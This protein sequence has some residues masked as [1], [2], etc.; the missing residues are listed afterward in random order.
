MDADFCDFSIIQFDMFSSPDIGLVILL[1][2][3]KSLLRMFSF[4]DN[5]IIFLFKKRKIHYKKILTKMM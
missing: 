1:F 4:G 5:W 2:V 3:S